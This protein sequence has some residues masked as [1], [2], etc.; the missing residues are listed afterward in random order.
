M[1]LHHSL[2]G[3][4]A[5]ILERIASAECDCS[6]DPLQPEPPPNA[7]AFQHVRGARGSGGKATFC[8]SPGGFTPL[9]TRES[10]LMLRLRSAIASNRC[11]SSRF[12]RP[13][14]RR[15]KAALCPGFARRL[16]AIAVARHA[17]HDLLFDARKRPASMEITQHTRG[18]CIFLLQQPHFAFRQRDYSISH[19]ARS[20]I[21]YP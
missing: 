21:T 2:I 13:T 11:R 9:S 7:A 14:F 1:R 19:S 3:A 8:F 12:T 10:G 4:D 15:A 16:Q 18:C 5:A 17:T 6:S 20:P